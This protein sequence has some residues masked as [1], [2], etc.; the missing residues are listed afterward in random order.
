MRT[1]LEYQ[2]DLIRNEVVSKTSFEDEIRMEDVIRKYCER[3]L[4]GIRTW[5]SVL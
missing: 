2:L 3:T 5:I 1:F 4:F